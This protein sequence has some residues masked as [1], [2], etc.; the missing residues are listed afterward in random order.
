MSFRIVAPF[1]VTPAALVTANVPEP[2]GNAAYAGGT[3]YAAGNQVVE[4]KISYVSLQNGNTGHDPAT[5]PTW[6][7]PI[8]PRPWI[9]GNAY[10]ATDVVSNN[11]RTYVC[12]VGVTS[13]TAPG[14]DA[15]HWTDTGPTSTWAP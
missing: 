14:S 8:G 5:S 15:A 1:A 10:V 3:T 11:H 7:W 2:A 9:S 6:W 4:A 13:A 12:A